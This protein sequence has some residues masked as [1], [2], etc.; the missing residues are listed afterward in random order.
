MSQ[1]CDA[2]S[3]GDTQCANPQ[4]TP[5]TS[6][7]RLRR[8]LLEGLDLRCDGSDLGGHD[9]SQATSRVE[10]RQELL[11]RLKLRLQLGYVEKYLG[12]SLLEPHASN[13]LKSVEEA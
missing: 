8:L 12:S 9:T 2:E 4:V 13:V 6:A 11:F 5:A 7:F 1:H 3:K 10:V